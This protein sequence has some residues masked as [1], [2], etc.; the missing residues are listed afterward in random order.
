MAG[1]KVYEDRRA[2]SFQILK[3]TDLRREKIS[4]V[5]QNIEEKLQTLEEEKN[6][7]QQFIACDKKERAIKHCIHNLAH[8]DA[9]KKVRSSH[10]QLRHFLPL[11]TTFYHFFFSLCTR[12]NLPPHVFNSSLKMRMTTA[13]KIGKLKTAMTRLIDLLSM[14]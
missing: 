7:L 14:S 1:T 2:Q 13:S 9:L 3:K 5:I 6:D 8:E 10:E 4:E 11:F 12:A